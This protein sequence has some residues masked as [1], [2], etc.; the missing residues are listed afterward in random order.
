M[1]YMK[2]IQLLC[3]MALMLQFAQGGEPEP[4]FLSHE[5]V[6]KE[7]AKS[8]LKSSLIEEPLSKVGKE[9]E[10]NLVPLNEFLPASDL[11]ALETGREKSLVMG[12]PSDAPKEVDL[13]H[14]DTPIKKQDN[15]KCTAYSLTAGIEST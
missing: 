1:S 3:I 4:R 9:H 5:E 15:G 14:R 6:L 2:L 7:L 13:R 12:V 10:K 11:K 8:G